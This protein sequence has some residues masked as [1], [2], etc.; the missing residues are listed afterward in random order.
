LH[1]GREE[2]APSFDWA[3]LDY[4]FDG[5]FTGATYHISVQEAR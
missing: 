2:H 4:I 5:P 3:G 1:A